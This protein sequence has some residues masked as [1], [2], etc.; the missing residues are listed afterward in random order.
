MYAKIMSDGRE[1]CLSCA[2]E[3]DGVLV[4]IRER[5]ERLVCDACGREGE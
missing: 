5:G 2:E 3:S 4:D 1:L